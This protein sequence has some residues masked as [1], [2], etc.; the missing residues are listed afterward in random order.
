MA[1]TGWLLKGEAVRH[2]APIGW[3]CRAPHPWQAFHF[4]LHRALKK[5]EAMIARCAAVWLVERDEARRGHCG[6]HVSGGAAAPMSTTATPASGRRSPRS[7]TRSSGATA[8][9][10]LPGR[11]WKGWEQGRRVVLPDSG[12]EAS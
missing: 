6:R 5:Q 2:L 9:S 4:G 11:W 7:P 3:H 10:A 1:A 8:W 12:T